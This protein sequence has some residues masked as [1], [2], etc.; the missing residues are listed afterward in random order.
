MIRISKLADYA[1]VILGTLAQNQGNTAVSSATAVA[2]TTHLPETTVAKIMK[3][4]A[5]ENLLIATRGATGGYALTKPA[6]QISVRE[7]VEAID[8]PIGVVDCA[9]ESRSECQLHDSCA[10]KTNWSIVNDTIRAS[11]HHVTLADMMTRMREA[12]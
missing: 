3:T 10:M 11:L 4:L 8:G 5:R 2:A 1:V 12:A 6:Y 7:I 9:E